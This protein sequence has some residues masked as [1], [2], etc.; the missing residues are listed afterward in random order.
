MISLVTTASLEAPAP[1]GI[2][3][4]RAELR[5]AVIAGVLLG[6]GWLLGF[7]SDAPWA[8]APVWASLAIGLLY[9]GRAAGEALRSG[10]FN[11][12]VLMV[13][14]AVFAAIVGHPDEGALLLFLFVLAGALEELAMMRTEREVR[15]LSALIPTLAIVQRG[16]EWVEASPESLIVG[17]RV[18][19]RP[20]ESVPADARVVQGATSM[21]Q[22]TLTG[23]SMPREV[24]VDDAIYAGT[25]NVE[26]P[27]EAI[28]ERA[29]SES[30]VQKILNLVLSAREQREPVQRVIDRISQ[31]YA[32]GVT[33]V[34]VAVAIVWMLAL[35][36]DWRE[37]A[38]TAI[39]FL[40]VCSPCALV[41]ATP[42]ATLAAIARGA[43]SGVLFKGGQ[44]IERLARVRAVCFDKTGT[45]TVGRPRLEAVMPV[46][47]SDG[48][49]LLAI[50]SALEQESTHPIA[51]AVRDGAKARGIASATL[52]SITHEAGRGMAGVVGG[53]VGGGAGGV[54]VRLGSYPHTEEIIPVCLRAHTRETL[55]QIRSHGRIGIVVAGEGAAG[56]EGTNGPEHAGGTDGA[57]GVGGAAVLVLRDMVRPG[58]KALVDHLHTLGVR[59]VKMLT[60][61]N[62]TTAAFVAKELG[63]DEFEAELMPADKL[64]LVQEIKDRLAAEGAG[65]KKGGVAVIGD[66]VNDA[67]ALAAA[68]VSIAIG[69][70]GS[71]AALE[72][73]DIV[74][75]NDDLSAVGWAMAL[76]R[77][78]RRTVTVNLA[79]ALSVIFVMG[80]TTLV[81]SAIGR[82]VPLGVGVLAHEGGTLLVVANS[83]RLLIG[84]AFRAARIAEPA[85][86]LP[87]DAPAATVQPVTA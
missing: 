37:S 69:S 21:D 62:R 72:S 79:F 40:I 65:R 6:L 31:P 16:G 17:E 12:D 4:P 24:G 38:Y 35:G 85:A 45:L 83:L 71:D 84:P 19:V 87:S 18:K 22:A 49:A 20:G 36:R 11:I 1:A 61:D 34:S 80:V 33:L 66:G 78:A 8:V 59:P 23:E 30:S 58:A 27:I 13:L 42:T 29:A 76:A 70:I 15:A 2:F 86:G 39:T 7:A 28:V 48:D 43:K 5:G 3:S 46:G 47:W 77:R 9:G 68:D 73:A 44:S 25:I 41:I 67:P 54:R 63:L 14:G 51:T 81:G 74:L 56:V 50:A 53:A 55:E 75:L 10:A 26:N 32:I 57:G 64:R 82:R 60:G 52:E